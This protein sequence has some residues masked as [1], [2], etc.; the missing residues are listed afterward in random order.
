MKKKDWQPPGLD[1]EKFGKT[2]SAAPKIALEIS[3]LEK[4]SMRKGRFILR[5]KG[6]GF[7]SEFLTK[8]KKLK[9][10]LGAPYP[11]ISTNRNLGS[12]GL[13]K[14]NWKFFKREK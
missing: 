11:K 5:K 9:P 10:T 1:A 6:G 4:P 13:T 12:K 3:P 2:R 14:K 8:P 7:R